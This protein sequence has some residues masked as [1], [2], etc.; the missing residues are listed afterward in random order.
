MTSASSQRAAKPFS[1]LGCTPLAE[2]CATHS[3]TSSQ[4][5]W[6]ISHAYQQPSAFARSSGAGIAPQRTPPESPI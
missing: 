2:A 5:L 3:L 6:V 1:D 4:T